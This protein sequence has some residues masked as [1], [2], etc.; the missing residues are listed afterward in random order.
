MTVLIFLNSQNPFI[1][2]FYMTASLFEF[3][4]IL[5]CVWSLLLCW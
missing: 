3:W 1:A 5:L 2:L 4:N